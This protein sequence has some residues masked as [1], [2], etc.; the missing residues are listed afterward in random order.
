MWKKL[1]HGTECVG[2][3]VH[4][5]NLAYTDSKLSVLFAS[6]NDYKENDS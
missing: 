5:E 2:V 1:N 4:K 6:N 3:W